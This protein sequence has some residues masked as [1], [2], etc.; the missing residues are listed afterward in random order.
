MGKKISADK[1]HLP[2]S[3][4]LPGCPFDPLPFYLL[5]DKIFSLKAWLMRLYPTKMLQEDQSIYNYRHS[6]PRR[7]IENA[8]GIFVERWRI[9][10]T[11]I[12]A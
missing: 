12:N 5:G 11:P 8:F 2:E 7:I 4:S 10:N 6:L 9:F 3:K 1:V